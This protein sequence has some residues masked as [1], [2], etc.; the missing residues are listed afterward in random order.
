MTVIKADAY[1]KDK[2][3][4]EIYTLLENGDREF[5]PPLSSRSSTTQSTMTPIESG[6]GIRDYFNE[7]IKQPL[8]IAMEDGEL[9]GFVSY[10]EDHVTDVIDV[11]TLPNIYVST[12]MV[13]ES[14]RGKGLTK[15]M[16]TVL[17]DE[18]YPERSVFTRTWS[19]NYAHIRILSAFGFDELL[20]L[21]DHRG[22]GIDTVYYVKKK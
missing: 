6:N 5:V 21:K 14:A 18:L 2:Y 20:R 15:R 11:S 10:R 17:F 7:M 4:K 8:L 3:S 19:T 12:L 22:A 9:M 16:Y 1:T 13:A